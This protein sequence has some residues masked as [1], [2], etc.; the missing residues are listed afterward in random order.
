MNGTD[1][2]IDNLI[3][4]NPQ[5]LHENREEAT[6]AFI[7]YQSQQFALKGIKGGSA[8]YRLLNGNWKFAW[9][10]R[11]DAAPEN[12]SA[13][14]FDVSKWD[15]IQVPLNWQMCGYDIPQYS[16]LNYPFPVDPPY[17]PTENPAGLYVRAFS[18]PEIWD[19][20][21]IFLNFEGV[22]SCFSVWVNGKYIGYSQGS[23]LPSSF[24][25]TD[26]ATKG[27]NRLAVKVLKW[28]DGSYLEDQDFYRLSGIFRDVYLLARDKTHLKDIFINTDLDRKYKDA[29]VS[30]ELSFNTQLCTDAEFS[31]LN[32]DN[33]CIA[34]KSIS[35]G[36][37][38][39]QVEF[40]IENAEKWTAETPLLYKAVLT[41][42][43]ETIAV[44]FG[45]RKI[46]AA[47]NG[48]LL[49]NGV[50]VKL[51]G[52]NRHDSHPD[53]GHYTPVEHMHKDLMQMKRHNI[54]TI[55]T[56]HYPNTPEFLNL[57]DKYGFYVIDETDLETH[58]IYVI[59]N[60]FLTDSPEWQSAYLDRIQR[61]VERDKN[62]ACV[63]MWSMGNESFMGKNHIAMINWAKSRDRSRLI[64]YEGAS[65]HCFEEDGRD[66]NCVDVVSRMYPPAAWC[67]EYCES[68]KDTRPY[69]LCEYSHAMGVGP[70]N[71]KEYW[72]LIYKYPN[73]IGGCIWEW[74][75]HSVR[76]KTADGKDFFVYGGYFGD[77]PNDGNFCCDGLNFP[78]RQAHT[79]LL[80]YKK[81][82]QP[83][84]VEPVDLTNGCLKITNLYDFT[85]LLSLEM[86]WKIE[87]D[88]KIFSQGRVSDLNIGAHESGTL[89]LGYG[90]PPSDCAEYY[91]TLSFV[92]KFDTAW[93]PYG[94]ETAFEQF[95]L[96]V[97]LSVPTNK[98]SIA[99][100][101]VE[102]VSGNVKISGENFEYFFSPSDGCFESIKLGGVQMLAGLPKFSVWRAPTDNDR[103]IQIKWREQ[104][105]DNAF[106]R[107]YKCEMAERTE[108]SVTIKVSLALGGKAVEPALKAEVSYTVYGNGEVA[109]DCSANIRENLMDIPRFGME[110]QLPNGNEN[111]K[112][113][114]M[115][116]HENYAD[117]FHSAKM[118][119]YTSTVDDQYTPYIM[120]QETG[121]HTC[122]KWVCVSDISGR[123]IVFKSNGSMNFSALH[124]TAEDLDKANLVTELRRRAETIV[125]IDY[126]QTGIGSNSCGPKLDEHYAFNEKHLDFSF[127][128][129]P[130]FIEDYDLNEE[131]RNITSY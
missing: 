47:E 70:G 122:V 5:I 66:N 16:N 54:N 46:E 99:P 45:V 113:F 22:N 117:M 88:G 35:K 20:K 48:A 55:R 4:Q 77:M 60:T 102:E 31:I 75:D 32:S 110:F 49:I 17:V 40:L 58:G 97:K 101:H 119:L 69:F 83:V 25:I 21:E 130:I 38:K 34:K 87:R 127:S 91:L 92:Q 71:L 3:W 36:Q 107:V 61:M 79:G 118:G 80:E 98:P 39:Y 7:P 1:W 105:L 2:S 74:C 124:Y 106:T 121:N 64:H 86:N 15:E 50:A 56:S 11:Y 6:A 14:D 41:H 62:H 108:T 84:R 73:F 123:G 89:T 93:E 63:I 43:N 59:E 30:A 27:E 85:S 8:F 18:V 65:Q 13:A 76:Q 19:G 78:D 67:E 9:F 23:H 111:L 82:I 81:I 42:E 12:F 94:F 109:V 90:V 104:L 125:H 120:P 100:I 52:V 57:C 131:G 29:V 44:A 68:G 53:L 112:Y 114:G 26:A 28:C 24:N 103:N 129:K 128:F 116:P 96:P 37:S 95:K 10:N 115:G 72:D 126:K 51:K 33:V